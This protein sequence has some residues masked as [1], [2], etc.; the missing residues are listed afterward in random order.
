[1]FMKMILDTDQRKL[2]KLRSSVLID[3]AESDEKSIFKTEKITDKAKM[4]DLYVQNLREKEIDQRDVRL[5]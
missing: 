5:L 4:L 1:M 2:L 3:S